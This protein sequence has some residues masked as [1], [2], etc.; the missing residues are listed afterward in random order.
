MHGKKISRKTGQQSWRVAQD[1]KTTR[2]VQ[3]YYNPAVI[4]TGSYMG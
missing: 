3:A 4:R 1:P 2:E